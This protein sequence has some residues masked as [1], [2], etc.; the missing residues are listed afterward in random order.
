MKKFSRLKLQFLNFWFI[1]R[2]T[3][4]TFSIF[5]LAL[6]T[7]EIIVRTRE[8]RHRTFK[9]ILDIYTI[10]FYLERK[11][12]FI[13]KLAVLLRVPVAPRKFLSKSM[14]DPNSFPTR[15]SSDLG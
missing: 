11:K 8:G 9:K 2:K 1:E 7:L 15:R 14:K 4:R 5:I 6:G 13:N 10:P 12:L 3:A